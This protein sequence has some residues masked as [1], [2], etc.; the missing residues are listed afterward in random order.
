MLPCSSVGQSRPNWSLVS[1]VGSY[2]TTDPGITYGC[3]QNWWGGSFC[4]CPHNE[5]PAS[6]GPLFFGN[7]H[8]DINKN[9][10]MAITKEIFN[11]AHHKK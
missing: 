1:Y 11:I 9:N 8:I 4:A 6:L 5:S 10:I 7:S 2:H 3:F